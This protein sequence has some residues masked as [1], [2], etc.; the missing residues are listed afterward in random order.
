MRVIPK[1]TT[2]TDNWALWRDRAVGKEIACWS[3]WLREARENPW[4]H[5][6]HMCFD[7]FLNFI[8]IEQLDEPRNVWN[9]RVLAE[10]SV[11]RVFVFCFLFFKRQ[12]ERLGFEQPTQ[13]PIS[14]HVYER[15]ELFLHWFTWFEMSWSGLIALRH[16]D[17]AAH[18]QSRG[19]T[20][21]AKCGPHFLVG[22]PR[23]ASRKES[24]CHRG[25]QGDRKRDG[26]SSGED[27]SPCGGDSEVRRN[28]QEGEGPA[29]TTP[30]TH[31]CP[32]V[33]SF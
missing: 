32:D 8:S 24:D 23:D 11:H 31:M 10:S 27:G 9:S 20:S 3:W 6:E 19:R 22:F 21:A 16:W 29:P 4:N 25:Q 17:K 2:C 5:C 1:F 14:E 13:T 12:Q 28:S 30:C 7:D 26:L 33:S 18:P 15:L